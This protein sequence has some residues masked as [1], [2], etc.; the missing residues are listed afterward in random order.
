[1]WAWNGTHLNRLTPLIN[2]TMHQDLAISM[3]LS[4]QHS[5]PRKPFILILSSTSLQLYHGF[6]WLRNKEKEDQTLWLK[7][8]QCS[9]VP[10]I[11]FCSKTFRNHGKSVFKHHSFRQMYSETKKKSTLKNNQIFLAYNIIEQ[12]KKA[13]QTADKRNILICL[14]WYPDQDMTLRQNNKFS[15]QL[16]CLRIESKSITG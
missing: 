8:Q 16:K 12:L 2:V 15:A 11:H 14:R 3:H 13:C 1:M 7:W 6:L 4:F 10:S 9:T 5:L